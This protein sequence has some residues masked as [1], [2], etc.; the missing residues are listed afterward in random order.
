MTTG[1]KEKG[2]PGVVGKAGHGTAVTVRVRPL[3]VLLSALVC[4]YGASLL[5][6]RDPAVIVPGSAYYAKR[7]DDRRDFLARLQYQFGREAVGVADVA[8]Q[9]GAA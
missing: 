3:A 7:S 6:M 8:G 9:G 1:F 5:R 2:L 4:Q